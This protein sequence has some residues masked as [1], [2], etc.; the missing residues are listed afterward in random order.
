MDKKSEALIKKLENIEKKDAKNDDD[1]RFLIKNAGSGNA[2]TRSLI[3]RLLVDFSGEDAENAL[4]ACENFSVN[5][6]SL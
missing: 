1:L 6:I 5:S 2:E 3:A 4:W